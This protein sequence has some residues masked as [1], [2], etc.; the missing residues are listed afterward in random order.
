[1]FR[2]ILVPALLTLCVLCV[3]VSCN[4][5]FQGLANGGEFAAVKEEWPEVYTIIFDKNGANSGD[6]PDKQQVAAGETT[7]LPG[8]GDLWK[9]GYTFGGWNT[10]KDGSGETHNE[11]FEYKPSGRKS[12]ITLYAVWNLVVTATVIVTFDLNGGKMADETLFITPVTLS[13]GESLGDDFPNDPTRENFYFNGW[14]PSTDTS[15]QN[16]YCEDTPITANITLKAYW[17]ADE[18]TKYIVTFYLN[19]GTENVYAT[20]AVFSDANPATVTLPTPNP[21][22]TG[23]AFD[24]WNTAQD[25]T[26]SAFEA[27]TTVSADT[28]VYAKWT[29]NTYTVTFNKNEGD[30]EANPTTKTVT[31]P[32]DKVDALPDQPTRNDYHFVGWNTKADG[33]GTAFT[34]ATSVTAAIT[35]YA[36]W[37]AVVE[38]SFLV[39]FNKNTTDQG[40]TDASPTTKQV[41]PPADKVDALPAPP[42][43]VGFTF[44][45]WKDGEGTAFTATTPVTADITVYAQWA[46]S[47]YT[48]TF[49][50]NGGSPEPEPKENI[51]HGDTISEPATMTKTNYTFGGWYKE[52]AF[53][54]QWNFTTDTVTGNITLYAKWNKVQYT[55]TFDSTG[56]SSVPSATVDHGGKVPEPPDPTQT[57]HTFVGWYKESTLTTPWTFAT[58]TVTSAVTLY[59][60]WNPI[61]YTVTFNSNGGSSVTDASVEYD[62]KVTE[63]DDPT[64]NGYDFGGWYKE[65]DFTNEWDFDTDTVDGDITLFAKWTHNGETKFTVTFNGN[66]ADNE[67]DAPEPIEQEEVGESIELPEEGDLE[68][69]GFT[70][71]CWNTQGNGEGEDYAANTSYTPE[72]NI[73]L[74]AKWVEDDNS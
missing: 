33:T 46:A 35:V 6:A 17:T 51:S 34:A 58:D 1:M 38:G 60:K 3:S 14:Y 7:P 53:T 16:I 71:D 59:A 11:D 12:D 62:S 36:K 27:N 61:T 20:K 2:K 28:K 18:K 9:E 54:N 8:K 57:G 63:P 64:R 41:A 52:A 23:Y 24:V 68:R 29:A 15:Y 69:T 32:N 21:T 42:T 4:I 50:A 48:V 37:E 31:Y 67:E 72:D 30:T 56:G 70:F 22:R 39:T 5:L 40:S 26:E 19:D 73:T 55:V 66:G 10:K 47:K 65:S 44:D 49:E 25:G 13:P 74:Y 45:G 43:R